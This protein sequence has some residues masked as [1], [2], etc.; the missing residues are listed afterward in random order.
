[1]TAKTQATMMNDAIN[2][3]YDSTTIHPI[4]AA[5]L[6]ERIKKPEAK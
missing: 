5:L 6:A 2:Q 3:G 1:M 4:D